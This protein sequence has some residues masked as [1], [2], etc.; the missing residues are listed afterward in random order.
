[1]SVHAT[2]SSIRTPTR[3]PHEWLVVRELTAGDRT[4]WRAFCGIIV[5]GLIQLVLLLKEQGS[6][7][8][9]AGLDLGLQILSIFIG[10]ACCFWDGHSFGPLDLPRVTRKDGRELLP[11][12]VLA[13]LIT[14]LVGDLLAIGYVVVSGHSSPT[15]YLDDVCYLGGYALF[16]PTIWLLAGRPLSLGPNARALL[17]ACIVLCAIIT[18]SWV[19]ILGPTLQHA[20]AGLG[21]KIVFACYPLLSCMVLTSVI[22]AWMGTHDERHRPPLLLFTLALGILSVAVTANIYASLLGTYRTGDLSDAGWPVALMLSGLTV[23]VVRRQLTL[24]KSTEQHIEAGTSARTKAESALWRTL[25]PTAL[26]P[27]VALAALTFWLANGRQMT[28]GILAGGAILAGLVLVRQVIA[29]IEISRLTVSLRSSEEN[30]RH[31]A[32]HDLLTGLPNRAAL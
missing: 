24:E 19:P 31:Q 26:L 18:C 14:I 15:P 27:I 7:D 3:E 22:L 5:F 17:D 1:M 23:S 29:L 21:A 11:R 25:L 16:L 2:S 12:F 32:T 6:S 30:L 8:I 20:T 28:A 13:A 4:L 9:T 10:I